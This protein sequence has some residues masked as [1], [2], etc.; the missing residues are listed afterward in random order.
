MVRPAH[1]R[2]LVRP[3]VGT[4]PPMVGGPEPVLGSVGY[5]FFTHPDVHF[6][7]AVV[8]LAVVWALGD[9]ALAIVIWPNLVALIFLAPKVV[10]ETKSYFERQPRT[11]Y[12]QS[13]AAGD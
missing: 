7:G 4:L 1:N 5:T 13:D 3:V 12:Q 6:F 11:K 10:E 9:V 8:P 2:P